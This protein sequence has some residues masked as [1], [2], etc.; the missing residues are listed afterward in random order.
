MKELVP[1]ACGNLHEKILEAPL[2]Y[3]IEYQDGFPWPIMGACHDVNIK[4]PKSY[5][6]IMHQ[7]GKQRDGSKRQLQLCRANLFL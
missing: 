5:I 3:R 2:L 1:S 7:A 4:G 6:P